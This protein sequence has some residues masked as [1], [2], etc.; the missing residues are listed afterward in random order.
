M[1]LRTKNNKI[2]LYLFIGI[3]L[4]I[5][6]T[7]TV[8][9]SVPN[10][11]LG[12]AIIK[13]I[14][15]I[16]CLLFTI[17]YHDIKSK[18]T[19]FLAIAQGL[20]LV[21]DFFLTILVDNLE[22]AVTFFFLAHILHLV[23]II[24]E[25]GKINLY[26]IIIRI[27]LS[28]VGIVTFLILNVK[29][30]IVYIGCLYAV[31]LLMNTVDSWLLFNKDRKYLPLAIGFTLFVGCDICVLLFNIENFDIGITLNKT[32]FQII[33]YGMW[34]FYLPSQV[35]IAISFKGKENEK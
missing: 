4:A 11:V 3:E 20:T 33:S 5:F 22:M 17:L 8:L 24:A 10:C 2:L 16:F 32:I 25:R 31:E 21:A 13:Y 27:A 35:L 19:I 28:I 14:G 12:S 7:F 15:V 1:N 23:H 34:T 30:Y 18:K 29:D 6:V 26:S 9:D